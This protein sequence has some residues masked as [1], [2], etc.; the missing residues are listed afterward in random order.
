M[1]KLYSFQSEE[2][3][4]RAVTTGESKNVNETSTI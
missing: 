4:K 1:V 3:A 2:R